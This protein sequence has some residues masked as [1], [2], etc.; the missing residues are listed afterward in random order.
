MVIVETM[1]KIEMRVPEISAC[2]QLSR[3]W[4]SSMSIMAPVKDDSS[5]LD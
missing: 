3:L 5:S 4:Y 1:E 2:V